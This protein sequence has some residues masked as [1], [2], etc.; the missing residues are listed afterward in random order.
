MVQLLHSDSD[1][2]DSDFFQE[3]SCTCL[4]DILPLAPTA[5]FCASLTDNSTNSGIL[6]LGTPPG[7]QHFS[8]LPV[9]QCQILAFC[10][11]WQIPGW[12]V[13]LL[14]Q[15]AYC[16]LA[17][18]QSQWKELMIMEKT[19]QTDSLSFLFV[20]YNIMLSCRM[21]LVPLPH[22]NEWWGNQ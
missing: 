7:D 10:M 6:Q 4:L 11:Y 18:C 15:A 16:Q 21:W 14:K 1:I 9:T 8:L 13:Y 12:F 3:H 22:A 20:F 19:S 2:S 17:Q 5:A